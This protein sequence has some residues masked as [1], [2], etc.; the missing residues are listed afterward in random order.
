VETVVRV[1]Q[2]ATVVLQVLRLR[3]VLRVQE[4]LRELQVRCMSVDL[5]HEMMELSKH[6]HIRQ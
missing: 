5:L 1:A 6:I 3:A 4:Q 2:V